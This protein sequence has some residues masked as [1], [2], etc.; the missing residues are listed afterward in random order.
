MN[1]SEVAS[2]NVSTQLRVDNQGSNRFSP[3][4]AGNGDSE[5]LPCRY[6]FVWPSFGVFSL[7]IPK[8]D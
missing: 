8:T 1:Q 6:A 2:A 4:E 7:L 3:A 5:P